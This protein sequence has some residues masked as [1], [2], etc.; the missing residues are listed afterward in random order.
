MLDGVARAGHERVEEGD[1]LHHEEKLPLREETSAVRS[2][3]IRRAS[4]R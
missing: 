1:R 3:R 4:S 2:R